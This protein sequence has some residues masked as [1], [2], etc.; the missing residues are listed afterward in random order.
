ML[1]T[2]PNFPLM[3]K[4]PPKPHN[5]NERYFLYEMRVVLSD[6]V[7]GL[8]TYTGVAHLLIHLIGLL[9]FALL[10]VSVRNLSLDF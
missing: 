6:G 3:H 8:I 9:E 10:E 2:K 1:P 4:F 7:G 5:F